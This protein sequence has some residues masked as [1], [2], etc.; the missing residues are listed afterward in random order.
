[1]VWTGVRVE[2]GDILHTAFETWSQW[3][4]AGHDASSWAVPQGSFVYGSTDFSAAGTMLA[5]VRNDDG[6]GNRLFGAGTSGGLFYGQD[7]A[8][9]AALVTAAVPGDTNLDGKVD[10]TD[11]GNIASSYDSIGGIR[12]SAGDFNYS[13]RVDVTDLGDFASTYGMS[14]GPSASAAVAATTSISAA[15]PMAMLATN[16]LVTVDSTRDW[17]PRRVRWLLAD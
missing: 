16:G 7:P 11:L 15:R 6:R 4:A 14:S 3:Q 17:K 13:G 8:L 2:E 10:V 1:V 12:W 5:I 9:D